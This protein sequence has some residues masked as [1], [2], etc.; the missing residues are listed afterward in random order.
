MDLARAGPRATPGA[1]FLRAWLAGLL[2]APAGRMNLGIRV[3]NLR[4]IKPGSPRTEPEQ[5]ASAIRE[6]RSVLSY[7]TV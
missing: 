5:E 6:F 1:C 4:S 3:L 2:M 7:P